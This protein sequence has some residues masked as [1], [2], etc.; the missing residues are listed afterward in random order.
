M[1]SAAQLY[2]GLYT[3]G[4]IDCYDRAIVG[5]EFA[6]RGRANEVERTLKMAYL[7]RF[8]AL[9]PQSDVPTIRSDNGVIFQSRWFREE[10]RLPGT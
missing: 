5:W 6:R 1:R 7:A 8:G 3:G 4:G 2:L 9:R 10:C